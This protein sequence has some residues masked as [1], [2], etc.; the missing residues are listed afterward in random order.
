MPRVMFG[1]LA[2]IAV[3]SHSVFTQAADG[4]DDTSTKAKSSEAKSANSVQSCVDDHLSGQELRQE[5][6]L[7]DSRVHLLRCAQ[8]QCP[9]LV[10]SECLRMLDELRA[11]VPSV[12]FR[13]TVDG[14][15]SSNVAASIGDRQ[16]FT[17]IP[18]RAMEF[19]PGKYRFRF[20]Y[21]SLAPIE[22]DIT[23]AEGERFMP[24]SVA[25]E[26]PT[27][28]AGK[29]G[30]TPATPTSEPPA[31]RLERRPIPWPVYAL[32][33]VGAVGLGGFVGFGLAT[34]SKENDLRSSCS[35]R[36]SQDQIDSLEQ[37]ARIAD[38]SLGIGAV[39]LALSA[40]VYFLRPTETI[41]VG[42]TVLPSGGSL[43][44]LEVDF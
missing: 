17:E 23:I 15:S 21:G 38:I 31:T 37:R 32:A 43:T 10:R 33:G 27:R 19:D 42:T 18:S 3:F 6:R 28:P 41:R 11:Q 16:L 26:S 25:F 34:R 2:G 39:A 20:E 29:T 14:E 4:S 35:P 36:C 22:R 30:N 9:E 5:G 8:P 44:R 40:T 13:V 7:L 1:F 12:V 24:I